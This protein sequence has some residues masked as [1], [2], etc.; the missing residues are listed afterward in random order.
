MDEQ[1]VVGYGNG[2]KHGKGPE[3]SFNN[4]SAHCHGSAVRKA[5]VSTSR[6]DNEKGSLMTSSGPRL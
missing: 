4:S 1:M 6:Q 3:I 2:E 5:L